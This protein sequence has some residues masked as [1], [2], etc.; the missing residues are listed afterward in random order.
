MLPPFAMIPFQNPPLETL[1][2][3][4]VPPQTLAVVGLSPNPARPSH[5]VARA[6]QRFGFRIIPVRPGVGQVLGERAYRRLEE[7]QE[8]VDI[9]VVFRAPEQIGPVVDA[10]I[11]RNDRFLWLQDGVVNVD[12]AERAQAAG[13]MV[14]M[15]RCIWRDYVQWRT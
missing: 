10:C 2:Q 11:A 7:V 8:P 15:D 9:V 14:V 12:E 1:R 6:M 4:V 3:I 5:G 13:I